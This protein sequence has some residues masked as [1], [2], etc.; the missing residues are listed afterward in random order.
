MKRTVL[1]GLM[2]AA[3]PCSGGPASPSVL[4]CTAVAS[5]GCSD[6]GICID[7][8]GVRGQRYTFDLRKMLFSGPRSSGSIREQRVDEAGRQVLVISADQRLV[9]DAGRYFDHSIDRERVVSRF[10]YGKYDNTEM[11]CR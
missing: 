11:E 2:L 1:V 5:W 3:A 4:H 10:F 6:D 7:S 8:S 9:I